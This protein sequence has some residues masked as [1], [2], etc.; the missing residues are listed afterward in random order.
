MSF[1]IGFTMLAAIAVVAVPV[2]ASA[3]DN[4]YYHSHQNRGNADNQLVGG[5]IGAVAGGVFGSQVAGNGARTEGSVLG[6]VL[7]GAAG[8]AIAGSGNNRGYS[9]GYYNVDIITQA[10]AIIIRAITQAITASR[11]ITRDPFIRV[12]STRRLS[13]QR[14]YIITR[15]PITAAIASPA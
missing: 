2:T 15:A 3:H 7:G 1:K 8:A 5:L 6:A 9:N 11:H 10:Q 13:M 4:G 14:L 12:L